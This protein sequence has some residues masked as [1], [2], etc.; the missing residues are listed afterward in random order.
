MRGAAGNSTQRSVLGTSLWRHA[1]AA[2]VFACA[3][4]LGGLAAAQD[5]K[6]PDSDGLVSKTLQKLK[7]KADPGTMP[8]FVVKSRPPADSLHYLPVGRPRPEP[9]TGPLTVDQ[10]KAEEA[11]LDGL[12]ERHDRVAKRKSAPATHASVADG[13]KLPPTKPKK[14]KCILT[15]DILKNPKPGDSSNP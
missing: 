11:E 10:I 4:G 12:R 5:D 8:D 7:L 15:C 6:A 13:R 2:T 14:P 1:V 9:A 3:L